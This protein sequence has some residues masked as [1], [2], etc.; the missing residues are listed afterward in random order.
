M[1]AGDVMTRHQAAE[2]EICD[3]D[4]A[5]YTQLRKLK[6]GKE[7]NPSGD[8]LCYFSFF[9]LA[10]FICTFRPLRLLRILLFYF[11]HKESSYSSS[12]VLFAHVGSELTRQWT[13]VGCVFYIYLPPTT[14]LCSSESIRDFGSTG[15][16]S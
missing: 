15:C 2:R 5:T 3:A 16:L 1:F 8:W 11:T 7:T 13:L 10:T 9:W 6:W 12:S 14:R 4:D